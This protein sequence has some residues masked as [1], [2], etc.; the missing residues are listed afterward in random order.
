M[1]VSWS[2]EYEPESPEPANAPECDRAYLHA[3]D[4]SESDECYYEDEFAARYWPE[5]FGDETDFQ[6]VNPAW[7]NFVEAAQS[8]SSEVSSTRIEAPTVPKSPHLCALPNVQG[9]CEPDEIDCVE[10]CLIASLEYM[11]DAL[12]SNRGLNFDAT[13][14]YAKSLI[15]TIEKMTKSRTPKAPKKEKST[16]QLSLI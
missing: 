5:F 8:V 10:T 2:N 16:A 7:D 13:L 14:L 15:K 6:C 4:P 11:R 9:H 3:S 12:A 1:S